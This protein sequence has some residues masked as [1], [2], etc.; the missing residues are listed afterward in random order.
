PGNSLK[1]RARVALPTNEWVHVTFTYDGSS[2]AA[3][4][5]I[6]LNG[7]P[8]NSEVLRDKLRKDITYKG[9]EPELA[10]G[11]RFRDAG[12]KGGE[13]DDFG[14]YHRF[15]T[16]IGLAGVGGRDDL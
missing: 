5:R 13:V 9:G 4:L 8:A 16:T 15:L 11:Y 1:V 3:G 2:R 6:F 7:A 14:V 12:F 10:I